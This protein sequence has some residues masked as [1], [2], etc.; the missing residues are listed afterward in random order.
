MA[1]SSTYPQPIQ[2]STVRAICREFRPHFREPAGRARI[3][4]R[5]M[6][7]ARR[8]IFD[9]SFPAVCHCISRCVRRAFLLEEAHRARMVQARIHFLASQMAIDVLEYAILA[10]HLHAVLATH[11]ELA[12]AW[13]DREVAARYRTICPD[14]AWRKR[15]GIDPAL[16]AREEEIA[17]AVAKPTLI[18]LWRRRLSCISFFHKLLKQEIARRCN[19]EDRVTGH[20][21][22]GRFKSIVALD[23]R[24]VIAHMAYVALN[25]VR[26]G[27]ASSLDGHEFSSVAARV[28]DLMAR[29]ARGEFS[30]EAR[31][32]RAKLR[33]LNLL[34]A[35]PCEPGD[36]V[37]R[38]ELL[39]GV[40]NPWSGAGTPAV[41]EGASLAAFL[42]DVDAQGRVE[43][44]GKRGFIPEETAR[45]LDMLDARL[46]ASI[47]QGRSPASR[48]IHAACSLG[49]SLEA[50][51]SR[52]SSGAWGNLSGAAAAIAEHAWRMGKR[53]A[54]AI[55][56]ECG[57]P[58]RI[59]AADPRPDP[60]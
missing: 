38:L 42:H 6:P 58:R 43:V 16:P 54:V 4:A 14:R 28:D 37:R 32:A 60:G 47:A 25:A 52:A 10:N 57:G 56:G 46:V 18:A 45:I 30:G 19:L 7:V 21:W 51:M 44:E 41:L 20:F 33:S 24:A 1:V 11:P 12:R 22:E 26:A 3:M 39:D 29:I 2:H 40:R 17:A 31:E 27:I 5:S 55:M 50:A 48:L 36:D 49:R 9:P 15:M 59:R 8:D 13:T 34:P 23:D 53:S 35:I